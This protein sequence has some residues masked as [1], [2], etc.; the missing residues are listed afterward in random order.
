MAILSIDSLISYVQSNYPTLPINAQWFN[1][2]FGKLKKS[3]TS[4]VAVM[5]TGSMGIT[6]ISGLPTTSNLPAETAGLFKDT[7]GGGVY[8]AYNDAGTIKKVQLS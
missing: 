4:I 2:E 7:S 8:L 1:N 5:R 3:I 6:P